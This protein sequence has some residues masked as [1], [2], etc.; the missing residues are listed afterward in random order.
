MT[1]L[2]ACGAAAA[3][4]TGLV[5]LAGC[6]GSSQA[7]PAAPSAP[8]TLLLGPTHTRFLVEVT[9]DG[10]TGGAQVLLDV[11]E[12][13]RGELL[14]TLTVAKVERARRAA[15]GAESPLAGLEGVVFRWRMSPAGVIS[16]ATG[17]AAPSRVSAETLQRALDLWALVS[18]TVPHLPDGP[19]AEEARWDAQQRTHAIG[20]GRERIVQVLGQWRL[21]KILAQA[22]A[23]VVLEAK[24]TIQVRDPLLP[25]EQQDGSA[26]RIEA[27]AVVYVNLER[28]AVDFA[29]VSSEA[30]SWQAR[31]L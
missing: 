12:A 11:R 18:A 20:G 6:G 3:L 16:A 1:P 8:P 5:L 25:P 28:R 15:P 17:P 7:A 23:T 29:T 24:L 22:P 19:V 27:R 14:A 4:A 2:R 26:R 13:E 31:R 21:A 30:F 9:T 10:N